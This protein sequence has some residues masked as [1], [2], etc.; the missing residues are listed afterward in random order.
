MPTQRRRKNPTRRG[1]SPIRDNE[2]GSRGEYRKPKSDSNLT[3]ILVV[4]IGLVLVV[5]LLITFNSKTKPLP[6]Q[7]APVAQQKV[8]P[9]KPVEPEPV[10]EVKPEVVKKKVKAP[11]PVEP[12]KKVEIEV[13][14]KTNKVAA[15]QEPAEK[16]EKPSKDDEVVIP[17]SFMG[18]LTNPDMEEKNKAKNIDKDG[19]REEATKKKE[20]N[21]ME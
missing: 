20:L 11:T 8:E 6:A 13:S 5:I 3:T 15:E 18:G 21:V 12:K 1:G 7:P 17:R 19:Q 16:V 9:V 10:E 14:G 4:M 2:S